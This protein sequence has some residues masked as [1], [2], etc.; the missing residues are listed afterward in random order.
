MAHPYWPFFDLRIRTPRLE[1]R[2]ACTVE[3]ITNLAALAAA[4]IHDADFMPFMTP[5]SVG[6]SPELER[7]A[8]QH[9]WALWGKFSADD[10]HVPF[11]VLADGELVGT[12]A[13][14]ADRFSLRKTV[15]TGS[16]LGKAHQG[17]GIGKEMRAAVLHFAFE[18][19]GA[20]RAETGAFH[21]N[22]PS[23][24]V[25]RSL[26]YRPNGDRIITR[27]GDKADVEY[28]YVMTVDEWRP[29]RRD[30]IELEGVDACLDMLGARSSDAP[31]T[32]GRTPPQG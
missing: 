15:V 1:L 12:Q 21:D 3:D 16:W 20:E 10:W 9:Y 18:G 23:I 24:G 7:K 6:P 30:D 8:M 28:E 4:G 26:G 11:A 14:G 17:M 29:R 32:E 27:G 13:V 22:A 19:V 2:P 25:T 5:W 31:A